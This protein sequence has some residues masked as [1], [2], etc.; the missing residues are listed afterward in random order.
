MSEETRAAGTEEADNMTSDDRARL[1]LIISVFSDIGDTDQTFW[2]DVE[3]AFNAS[4]L[5]GSPNRLLGEV[6][7]LA[8]ALRRTLIVAP[9]DIS[10]E[11]R[12]LARRFLA[13]LMFVNDAA[14]KR[15]NLPE[16]VAEPLRRLAKAYGGTV[17]RVYDERFRAHDWEY[18]D[19]GMSPDVGVTVDEA[20]TI[21]I[22]V[23]RYDGQTFTLQT[24]VPLQNSQR[25]L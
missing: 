7:W 14:L 13:M 5:I 9:I 21:R 8:P 10:D 19:V 3:N 4:A 20:A 17:S 25:V 2:D 6:D 15:A 23:Q 24:R 12:Q 18:V 11:D 1:E 22:V 16:Q